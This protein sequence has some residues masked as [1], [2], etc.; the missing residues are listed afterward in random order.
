MN[1]RWA[2]LEAM[3]ASGPARQRNRRGEGSLLRD[4]I[5]RAASDLLTTVGDT[6][7]LSLRAVAREAGVTAPSLYLHFANKAEVVEAVLRERFGELAAT[8][9]AA[10]EGIDDPAERLMARSH[11]FVD[12]GLTHPGHFKVMYEGSDLA[13]FRQV[14][15]P[16]NGQGIQALIEADVAALVAADRIPPADPTA[17]ALLLW[18]AIHGVIALRISKTSVAWRPVR[19]DTEAMV[20]AVVG[21]GAGDR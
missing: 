18:Q 10:A 14:P 9:G 16:G 4:D 7:A 8:V 6:D 15:W 21:I 11:A 2:T 20:R 19:E 17:V 12:F 1:P 3:S 13:A 5:V